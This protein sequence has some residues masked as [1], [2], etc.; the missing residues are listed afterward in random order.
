MP[1]SLEAWLEYQQQIHPDNIALGLERVALVWQR[2]GS[3]R[4]GATVLTVAGTNG[5]GSCVAMLESILAAAGDRVGTFTSPHLLEYNER[6]RIDQKKVDDQ[7]LC[8]AFAR[9]EA[10]RGDVALTYY[11]FGTLAALDILAR[12]RIDWAVLEVGLGGRLDAVNVI[13]SDCALITSIAIDHVGYLGPDRESIG[14]EKAAIGRP[15][16]P[17]ICGDPAPPDS[18]ATV[19]TQRSAPLWVVGRDFCFQMTDRDWCYR[20]ADRELCGLPHPGLAGPW[21]VANAATALA[22]LDALRWEGFKQPADIHHGLQRVRMAGRLQRISSTPE[23]VLD[24]AHNP[25]AAGEL[26]NW[27]SATGRRWQVVLGM[28]DDK[29]VG[30]FVSALSG[31]VDQWLL[32]PLESVRGLGV[33]ALSDQVRAVVGAD[34]IHACSS[35]IDALAAAREMSSPEDGILV[36]GSFYTVSEVLRAKAT[37]L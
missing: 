22:G 34:T 6:I 33:D 28:L 10:V 30:G 17:M 8:D 26:A 29:D 19:A 27:L 16:R 32:A 15:G 24:V 9:V 2:M 11:E 4:P 36:T 3:P 1:R 31:S 25:H 18:I 12:A 5:K 21:Q 23:V 13:D 35:V 7:P 37:P 14:A 20:R